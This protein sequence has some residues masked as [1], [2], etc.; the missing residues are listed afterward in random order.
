M[1]IPLK[2]F[3]D[4]DNRQALIYAFIFIALFVSST[5]GFSDLLT[6]MAM[7]AVFA[8]ISNES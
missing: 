7:G 3:H 8:N 4:E 5:F 1:L 6:C 2:F